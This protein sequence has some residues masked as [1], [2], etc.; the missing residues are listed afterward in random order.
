MADHPCLPQH[1][2]TF[3]WPRSIWIQQ[4]TGFS[5]RRGS[6]F[7]RFQGWIIPLGLRPFWAE[8]VFSRANT[9]PRRCAAP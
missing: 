7:S 4:I 9:A 1:H 2:L 3:P 8:R 5:P 6:S